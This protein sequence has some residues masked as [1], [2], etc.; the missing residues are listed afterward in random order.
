MGVSEDFINFGLKKSS[1]K[2]TEEKWETTTAGM[3]YCRLILIK[4]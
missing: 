2:D 3:T 4:L 1:I